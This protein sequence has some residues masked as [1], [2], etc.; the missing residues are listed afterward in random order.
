MT[1]LPIW[2]HSATKNGYQHLYKEGLGTS[3]KENMQL[4]WLNND[5][6]YTTT[7]VAEKKDIFLLSRIGATDPEFNL[8]REPAFIHRKTNVKDA[9]FVSVIESHGS[10]SP[11]SELA[12][13]AYSKI[14]NIEVLQND[15][16]Y[17][18]VQIET[19]D[20][21]SKI[22]ILANVDNSKTKKHQ[23][24]INNKNYDWSGSYYFK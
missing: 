11:V 21:A 12:L 15:I 20:G 23:L 18:A 6:F 1:P 22:F 5:R 4:N 24:S 7:S 9:I 10:Y 14:K 13:N 19:T 8:R 3:S 17:T 2:K 16:S